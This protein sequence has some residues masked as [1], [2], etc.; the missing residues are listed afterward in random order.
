MKFTPFY[1]SLFSSLLLLSCSQTKNNTNTHYHGDKVERWVGQ[2][3]LKDQEKLPFIFD[4]INNTSLIIH[5][6]NERITLEKTGQNG[7]STIYS[8]PD[9]ESELHLLLKENHAN[10]VWVS[11]NKTYQLPITAEKTN[12]EEFYIRSTSEIPKPISKKWRTVFSPD[13]EGKVMRPLL[14]FSNKKET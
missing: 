1:F 13:P 5:N 14:V 4:K 8:F 6:A 12:K 3:E 11:K 10:G 9:F 2:I 7:D